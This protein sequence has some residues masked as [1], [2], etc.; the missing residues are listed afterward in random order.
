MDLDLHFT[1]KSHGYTYPPDGFG[2]HGRVLRTAP[3][4][5]AT[6][7][8]RRDQIAERLYR[9]TGPGI[10]RD[11]V[12]TG[13][14]PPIARPLLNARVFG[15]DSALA[16]PYRGRLFWIWG[17]TSSP[18]HPLKANFR[19][20]AAWSDLPTSG[21]LDPELGV[22]LHYI[23]KDG[24]TKP[25]VS[26]GGRIY[27]LG[28]LFT[29]PDAAGNEVLLAHYGQIEPP[30]TTLGRGL[31]R[32]SDEKEEFELVHEIS[33]DAP[34]QPAGQRLPVRDGGEEYLVFPHGTHFTRV[35]PTLEA[36][37]D[38]SQWE[39][40]TCLKQGSRFEPS[41]EV[42]DRAPDGRL[43]FSWKR[44]TPPVGAK[45]LD[46]LT[47]AGL[48][49]GDARLFAFTD[50]ATGKPVRQ[51]GATITWNPYRRRWIMILSELFGTSVLG[52]VWYAE[53]DAPT[54]PW[55]Y[56]RKVVTHERY[57]FY[58]PIQHPYFAKEDGRVIFFEG[59]YTK[60]FS[61]N[62]I[63]TPRY[64]YNQV[65]YRLAL[66][67]PRLFLPV[68]V[69]ETGDGSGG[70][71]YSVRETTSS[72]PLY[73]AAAFFAP[74]RPMAGTLPV[75]ERR[76]GGTA[77]L[78]LL[79]TGTEVMEGDR[80]VFYGVPADAAEA[81]PATVPLHEYTRGTERRYAAGDVP[82]AG[83]DWTRGP[84]PVCLVWNNPARQVVVEAAR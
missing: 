30:M 84:K 43:R 78:E 60:G 10:Y 75:V 35:R 21:G 48:V 50:I 26:L 53:A 12:L 62:E 22:N 83:E 51:H 7:A 1:F 72:E 31:I 39:A 11:T 80:V 14:H 47:S 34:I 18:G 46:E 40:F 23:E 79:T 59:T 27:W 61:G 4:T 69:Y 15:Q 6:V 81:P 42:L 55:V 82:P 19:T 44:N 8:M 37:S 2:V 24:F 41:A 16:T 36:V 32:F 20:T 9:I 66:D 70:V 67:D 38:L 28:S 56:A 17:D 77:R 74:D 57:S 71:R 54:G 58:N 68:A 64:D 76:T 65:M 49:T 63:S 3:G 13:G 29:V 45:E 33:L 5:S 52:E 73:R 25:M